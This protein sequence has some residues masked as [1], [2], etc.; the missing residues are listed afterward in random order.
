MSTLSYNDS[1]K[2]IKDSCH[3]KLTFLD[4]VI[5]QCN[6]FIESNQKFIK[7]ISQI[8]L[9]IPS[10]RSKGLTNFVNNVKGPTNFKGTEPEFMQ[11]LNEICQIVFSS[12]PGLQKEVQYFQDA[13]VTKIIEARKR[14]ETNSNNMIQMGNYCAQMLVSITNEY[15]KAMSKY[16]DL[17]KELEN[18]YPK[19]DDPKISSKYS[20]TLDA[21]YAA[22]E[23]V[24]NLHNKRNDAEASW[25]ANMEDILYKYEMLD[26]RLN[27]EISDAYINFSPF[28]E[29]IKEERDLITN[30]LKAAGETDQLSYDLRDTLRECSTSSGETIYAELTFPGLSFDPAKYLTR[31][32][33]EA[34]ESCRVAIL[35]QD[36][37]STAP[38][39]HDLKKGQVVL[40]RPD[41]S[42]ILFAQSGDFI[43]VILEGSYQS[44]V[45]SYIPKVGRAVKS[46]A[47][48]PEINVDDAVYIHYKSGP[49]A[50]ITTMNFE[51][52][53][54]PAEF[55]E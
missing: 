13:F 44:L 25:A 27:N 30:R 2:V 39:I 54:I 4:A 40:A 52:T 36:I 33:F 26:S 35:T 45:S 38:E 46:F 49:K 20:S 5:K 37:Q 21:F 7:S 32:T 28:I 9:D 42:G 14:F 15:N 34:V 50:Y 6:S 1:F 48:P 23:E 41:S 51:F 10:K 19:K 53:E 12:P 22:E 31:S 43:G 16:K 47:G 24:F 11:R 18:L 3:A 29:E 17:S 55:V 8:P